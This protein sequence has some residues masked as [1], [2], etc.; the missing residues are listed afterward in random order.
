MAA[1]R[2]VSCILIGFEVNDME[3]LL[4]CLPTRTKSAGT[5]LSVVVRRTAVVD[6]LMA[7]VTL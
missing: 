3:A 6:H 1:D 2:M 5:W 7:L 4:A